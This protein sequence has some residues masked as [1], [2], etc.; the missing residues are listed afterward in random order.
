MK[1]SQRKKSQLD[2][3]LKRDV[4]M[5]D[6]PGFNFLH[7][8]HCALPELDLEEIDA[9]GTLLGRKLTVPLLVSA[10]TGGYKKSGEINRTLASAAQE[11]G[12]AFCV[13]SQH[14]ALE[15]PE[16]VSTYQVRDVAENVF[17]FANLS[18]SQL[19][20]GKE[21]EEAEKAVEMIDADGLFLHLNPLQEAIQPEGKPKYK[22]VLEKIRKVCRELKVPVLVKETGCGISKE[23][24]REIE[25]AGAA[26]IDVAGAGGTSW[27]LVESYRGGKHGELFRDWGIPTPVCVAELAREV[28]IPVIAGGG[29]RSGLDAAKALALGA[30]AVS[31]AL[32]LLHA[33]RKGKRAVLDYLKNFQEELRL[34][35]FL[36]GCARVEELRRVPLVPTGELAD[37]FRAR[38]IRL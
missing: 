37:W 22:G 21:V 33:A 15:N 31:V 3:C 12:V 25:K 5:K 36:T 20:E 27:A 32:P 34:A 35:M 23:V 13:G 11:F 10:M 7:F 8:V 4:Q 1:L 28:K 16:L 19:T 26:G 29:I 14:A 30:S 18:A 24:G 38:G 2:I 6:V 9:G 17:L